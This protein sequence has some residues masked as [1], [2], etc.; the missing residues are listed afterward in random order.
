MAQSQASFFCTYHT[1]STHATVP[2]QLTSQFEII[3]TAPLDNITMFTQDAIDFPDVNNDTTIVI[4]KSTWFEHIQ[5]QT[6][7]ILGLAWSR[8]VSLL[9]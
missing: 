7:M 5:L 6:E 2:P 1:S 9:Y 8:S 4:G 3:P